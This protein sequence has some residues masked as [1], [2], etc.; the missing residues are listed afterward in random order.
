VPECIKVGSRSIRPG[1]SP[2]LLVE[3]VAIGAGCAASLAIVLWHLRQGFNLTDEGYYL[4][5]SRH[6]E[7]VRL[8]LTSFHQVIG[9]MAG[10]TN[11]TIVQYRMVAVL[12]ILSSSV[13]LGS[14]TA[15]AWFEDAP[16]RPVAMARAALW[17]ALGGMVYFTWGARGLSY[18]T[19]NTAL[20]YL[21]CGLLIVCSAT[22]Q[23]YSS[24]V[25]FVALYL[26]V[27]L[28]LGIHSLVKAPTAA[29]VGFV[30][31]LAL[32]W[33]APTG[34]RWK[35]VG[36]GSLAIGAVIAP[37]WF[38]T[39]VTTPVAWVEMTRA[40]QVEMA[41]FF[42][43]RALWLGTMSTSLGA[44]RR[45]GPFLLLAMGAVAYGARARRHGQIALARAME[46]SAI[47]TACSVVA[48]S[49]PILGVEDDKQRTWI[50]HFALIAVLGGGWLALKN[51]GLAG[52]TAGIAIL[53]VLLPELAALSSSNMVTIQMLL[54]LAPWFVLASLAAHEISRS[55][56]NL[57]SIFTPVLIATAVVVQV[58]AGQVIRPF[59]I[60]GR[61]A[62]QTVPLTG[63]SDVAAG[64]TVDK[65]TAS[66]VVALRSLL[67][68]GGFAQGD[69]I[70]GICDTPGLVFLAG[71]RAPETP[72]IF[73]G[74]GTEG[75][76]CMALERS[77]AS[78]AREF[79][80]LTRDPGPIFTACLQRSGRPIE[81]FR[82]LGSIP[83]PPLP[84]LGEV[85]SLR[86]YVRGQ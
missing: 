19:L 48:L 11:L 25:P 2:G 72:W 21:E 59:G 54:H 60:H 61:M 77:L 42:S 58:Y 82:L 8:T 81:S 3:V 49:G 70:W 33:T 17:A 36:A 5:G 39:C 34:G 23:R 67:D 52:R 45:V 13:A 30:A 35:A 64:L 31:L 63:A 20:C 50:P 29:L 4:L 14:A 65:E 79:L 83:R 28:L 1:W 6:P 12:L 69:P 41:P 24:R 10:L 62:N 27:G 26:L 18:N 76:G 47:A 43:L 78:G 7:D 68:A 86:V 32:R 9:R 15:W 37:V 44:L 55:G 38:F 71:G 75:F 40:V 22:A 73:S 57:V 51:T 80:L 85:E 16:G 66:L 53:L 84:L 56:A 74:K 46:L